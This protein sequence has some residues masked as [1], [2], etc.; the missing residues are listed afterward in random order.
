MRILI[1][2]DHYPPFIGGGQLTT[3]FLATRLVERGHE[4]AV[5]TVWQPG[6]SRIQVEGVPVHRLRQLRTSISLF[7]NQE[8]KYEQPPFADP[9][10][11]VALRRLIRS[12]QPDLVH[13]HGWFSH[14]CAAALVG[15]KI[16]L[17]LSAR[18]Y[19]Y[20][21]ANRTLLRRGE[22]CNGPALLKCIRCAGSNYGRPKGWIAAIS[23]L[24]GRK[25]LL[26]KTAGLHS[27]S[28]YVQKTLRRDLVRRHNR[29][30]AERVIHEFVTA[31]P[32]SLKEQ[33][34]EHYLRRLPREPF[35]L[36]V[37]AL[38]LVKGIA[39]LLAAYGRLDSPPPLVLIGTSEHDTPTKLPTGCVVLNDF[40]HAAVLRAWDRCLFGVIPSRLPE[41]F[42]MVLVEAMH[43]GKPV[44]TTV[45]GGHGDV[46]V[47]GVTGLL[48]QPG[49]VQALEEA[50][51]RLLSDP[52]LRRQLGQ[53]AYLRASRIT[54]DSAISAFEDLY[55]EVLGS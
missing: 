7:V 8:R 48:V 45:P 19:G 16:P 37:G 47:D 33:T 36:F 49:D 43:S 44:I 55:R 52:V 41:P 10:T 21:C 14:S 35:I 5:A 6:L 18:D 9:I 51:C 3:W 26:H 17:V 20:A 32:F 2:S 1:A 39:E 13:S 38:R 25:L 15:T 12:Y 30:I 50:M 27:V 4:V 42:G 23:V 40:P 54:P 29:P 34:I 28:A 53:A 46:V 31:D 11:V 22:I 24:A